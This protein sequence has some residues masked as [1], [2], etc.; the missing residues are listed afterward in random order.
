MR[1][2]IMWRST[3]EALMADEELVVENLQCDLRAAG[4]ELAIA[5]SKV[6]K[7]QL[8]ERDAKAEA[9]RARAARN[10]LEDTNVQL[11]EDLRLSRELSEKLVAMAQ[12]KAEPDAELSEAEKS[13]EQ[14]LDDIDAALKI[15]AETSP[16]VT[17]DRAKKRRDMAALVTKRAEISDKIGKINMPVTMPAPQEQLST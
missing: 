8:A 13:L 2:P 1:N 15:T 4:H 17:R 6:V 9:V 14:Q 16:V 5:D 11:V 3:H 7:A 10:R 12:T